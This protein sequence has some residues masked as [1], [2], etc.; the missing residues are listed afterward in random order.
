MQTPISQDNWYKTLTRPDESI[1]VMDR[2]ELLP[3]CPERRNCE[4]LFTFPEREFS[5]G[6]WPM[7]GL[8]CSRELPDTYA[9]PD[10]IDWTQQFNRKKAE[11]KM[12]EIVLG[13]DV[14][15]T[16]DLE[17]ENGGCTWF[18]CLVYMCGITKNKNKKLF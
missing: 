17:G 9:Y 10:S 18:K 1:S 4:L 11:M 2:E 8:P 5:L 13:G 16:E 6:T 3:P 15:D 12:V 14:G 7:V